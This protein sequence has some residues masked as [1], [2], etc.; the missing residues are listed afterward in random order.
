MDTNGLI[1]L[2]SVVD[3][4]ANQLNDF[5]DSNTIRFMRFGERCLS[6]LHIFYLDNV[7][8]KTL[9]INKN[10]NA[11]P[12]PSDFV[13]L[14]RLGTRLS[15]GR[16]YTMT[17]DDTLELSNDN[18]LCDD[19]STLNEGFQVDDGSF[20]TVG[21]YSE[22]GRYRVNQDE[23]RI[24]FSPD[25]IL[26]EVTLEYVS[27]GVKIDGTTYIPLIAREA[28]IAYIIWKNSKSRS[29]PQNERMELKQEY[30]EELE[31]LNDALMPSFDEMY[32]ALLQGYAMV[33][34]R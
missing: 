4:V 10:I 7:T 26:E 22:F 25:V 14:I 16:L 15:N 20:S 3:D 33:T 17:S 28:V 1:T 12:L 2:Q 19:K 6:D 30:Y 21:G 31:K 13:R 27:S 8:T 34:T 24:E 23:F 18:V 9:K 32:D 11:T 29:I 5:S